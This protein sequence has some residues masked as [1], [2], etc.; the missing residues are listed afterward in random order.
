MSGYSNGGASL[1]KKTLKTWQPLSLSAKS[2]VDLNLTTL[3]N[4]SR[5]L[6]RNSAL[7]SAIIQTF[8]SSV[9]GSGLQL[10]PR[11]DAKLL[12]MSA[13]TAREW[14]RQVKREF[15]LWSEDC[16]YLRRN[17]FAELQ[18]I[19]FEAMLIDGDVF[20]LI[21]R[22]AETPYSL[23]L[24]LVE[25]GRV[26]NPGGGVTESVFKGNRVV[27]GIEV[28]GEGVLTAAHISNRLWMEPDAVD[29]KLEW[30]RVE[31]FGRETGCR[32]VLQICR[33]ERPDQFR[34][35]PLLAPVIE[36]LKQI[37][38]YCD[39][40]LTSSIIKSF[41]SVFFVQ[42]ASNFTLN[43]INDEPEELDVKDFKLGSG[44]ISA[45]PRGVDVKAINRQDSHNVFESFV[46]HFIKQVAAAVNLPF[47]VL[48]KNFQSSYS[49]SR[50]ALLQASSEFERRKAAFVRDFCQ[51]VYEQFLLEAVGTERINALGFEDPIK[52]QAY[53]QA[54]WYTRNRF[55]L[56][57]Q[58]ESS[59][60]VLRLQNGL[61]TY[62]KEILE[63]TGEDFNDVVETL[64]QEKELLKGVLNQSS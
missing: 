11:P 40:E 10:F 35:V 36:S 7:G 26:S 54:G 60:M 50:A 46:G 25:S 57:P 37:E 6:A 42:P 27:N 2:D 21:K 33:D 51:P 44:T 56:D 29:A 4:R 17:N 8:T 48:L 58:K 45:L 39:A 52:R 28:D 9:V 15:A 5:D 34:G 24:Q 31:F 12:G 64:A 63:S 53:C 19:A 43:E 13:E 18:S 41:F 55:I 30:Q 32:N 16:D 59:A 22:R 62:T 3:R 14:A 61:S 38:R 47:E 23:K 1:L 49:A 20:C